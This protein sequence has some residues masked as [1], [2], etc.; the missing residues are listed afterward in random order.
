L[1]NPA[2]TDDRDAEIREFIV[3]CPRAARPRVPARAIVYRNQ[4][5]HATRQSLL[6]PLPLRHVVIDDAARRGNT[7]DD[8]ARIAERGDE[9]P[10]A[11]LECDVDVAVHPLEVEL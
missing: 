8:P 5:V 11:F 7:I 10:Y 1:P 4:P 6:G 9:E 3:E 2:G